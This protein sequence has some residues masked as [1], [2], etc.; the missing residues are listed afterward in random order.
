MSTNLYISMSGRLKPT[1][2]IT[3]LFPVL[4]IFCSSATLL[5][6]HWTNIYLFCFTFFFIP[7]SFFFQKNNNH[8]DLNANNLWIYIY[9]LNQTKL[10]SNFSSQK[11]QIS[12]IKYTSFISLH[13]QASS[14]LS[15]R[16][17]GSHNEL[18]LHGP[19]WLSFCWIHRLMRYVTIQ[20]QCC[21][22]TYDYAACNVG[23]SSCATRWPHSGHEVTMSRTKYKSLFIDQHYQ[24]RINIMQCKHSSTN[25]MWKFCQ[26]VYLLEQIMYDFLQKKTAQIVH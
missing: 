7:F 15:F 22:S 18:P 1:L 9:N 14:L 6:C 16:W 23:E 13:G 20:T 5:M 4:A 3:I 24:T 26:W 25:L 10:V 21:N 11:L 2:E 12:Q 17:H 8:K 19:H